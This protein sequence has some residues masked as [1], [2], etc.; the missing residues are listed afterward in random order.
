MTIK[1]GGEK[2]HDLKLCHCNFLQPGDQLK[3][4]EEGDCV[5]CGKSHI[6]KNPFPSTDP[7]K[8]M[9]QEHWEYV[10]SVIKEYSGEKYENFQ[11][12]EFQYISAFIHGYKHGKEDNE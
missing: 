11:H 10:K 7:V 5:E 12:D 1:S 9:A 3:I 6:S 4:N 2:R 8:N